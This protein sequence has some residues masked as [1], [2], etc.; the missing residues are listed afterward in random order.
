MKVLLGIIFFH[1][2]VIFSSR[3]SKKKR[4]AIYFYN[5]DNVAAGFICN[6][7]DVHDGTPSTMIIEQKIPL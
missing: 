6:F 3:I 7:Y 2:L 5:G 4:D 1:V